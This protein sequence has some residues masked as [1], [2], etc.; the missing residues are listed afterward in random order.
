M[1]SNKIAANLTFCP[2]CDWKL[3]TELSLETN[4]NNNLNTKQT[5]LL[6]KNL[7]LEIIKI[8]FAIPVSI[9]LGILATFIQT[10]IALTFFNAQ[11]NSFSLN[12]MQSLVFLS[13]SIETPKIFKLKYQKICQYIICVFLVL[14]F[15]L[16]MF[17]DF[18]IGLLSLFL[19]FWVVNEIK[20]DNL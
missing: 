18:G 4:S 14:L 6:S 19:V 11:A 16:H 10:F 2:I 3:N 8:I 9:C 20:K 17:Y 15:I 12:F 7:C 1:K 13:A 5:K